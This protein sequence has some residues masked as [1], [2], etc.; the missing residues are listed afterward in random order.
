MNAAEH[1]SLLLMLVASIG[2]TLWFVLWIGRPRA[3]ANPPIAGLLSAWAW[4]SAAV[5]VLLLLVVL[6]LPAPVWLAVVVLAVRNAVWVWR[7]RALARARADDE[8]R[9]ITP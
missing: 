4:T 3:S 7:L 9:E 8:R 2:L 5:D 1:A 6:G